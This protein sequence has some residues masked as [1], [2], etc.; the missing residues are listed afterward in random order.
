MDTT[1]N[2]ALFAQ[3]NA[4]PGSDPRLL[5]MAEVFAVYLIWLVPALLVI[6]WL[7]GS[8][9]L[10]R[11]LWEAFIATLL[12]LAASWVIGWLWPTPRPFMMPVGQTFLEHAPTPAFPSNHA[13]I[14][15]TMAFS[16][17]LHAG[18]RRI[19]R[20]LLLLTL[21]VAWARVFLGV[22]FPQD[23]LGALVLAAA[24]ATLVG[25]SRSW[26]ILPFYHRVAMRL[27]R[28]LFAPLIRRGWVE[29]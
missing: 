22:H 17:L 14:M 11:P 21:P 25:A 20:Y 19:G 16:L 27:Y 12:A 23:M 7:R 5:L 29:R 26:L 9:R 13:T 2:L 15:L 24:M 10:K 8:E 3:L 1:L 28:I 18:T 4:A 6:G